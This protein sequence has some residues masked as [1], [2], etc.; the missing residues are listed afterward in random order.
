MYRSTSLVTSSSAR[1]EFSRK[2]WIA[3]ARVQP[4]TCI[5]VSTTSRTARHIS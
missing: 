1:G 5:P 4:F 3:L 2:Y